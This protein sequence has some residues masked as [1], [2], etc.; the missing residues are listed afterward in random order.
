MDQKTWLK[1]SA[2]HNRLPELNKH[3]KELDRKVR[4]L[5]NTLKVIHEI[6]K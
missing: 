6:N 1:A 4:D 5:E 2:I 3:I